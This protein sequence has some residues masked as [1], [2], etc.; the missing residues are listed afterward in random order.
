MSSKKITPILLAGGAGSRLWP[1]SRDDLPKQFQPLT[2]TFSTYQE[3]LRRVGDEA[4]YSPPIVI[5][6]EAFRFFSRRQ[7]EAAG[8]PATVVLEPARRDS[9]AAVAVAAVMAE[10]RA[11]ATLVLALAADH[12]V[13][14][15]DLF[16]KS[17]L[18]GAEAAAAGR[19]VVFGLKPTEPRTSYGYIRPGEAIDG[20]ADLALVDAFVEKPNAETALDYL[21]KGY[22]WNSG[23][24]LFR[25]DVMIA[26]FRKYAPE[27]LDAA[28]AS[29]D[30][31]STDLG[32]VRLDQ[33]SFEKAPKNSIDYA[34]IEKTKEMAV[35]TGH[36]RWSDVGSWDAIWEVLDRDEKD[37]VVYGDGMALNSSGCL[38]HSEGIY[39]T[40][41]GVDDL[42][43]IS[44]R[45]A[46][47]VVPKSKVQD[48]KK[49]VDE[50]K[51]A[52]VPQADGHRRSHRPWGTVDSVVEGAR[53]AV[54]HIT[55]DCGGV[56][57]LQKHM[58][59]S[60]HWVV[61]SGTATITIGEETRLVTENESVY[62]PLG[63]VHRIS[64]EGMVPL[65]LIEVRTGSYIHEDD[66]QRIEDIYART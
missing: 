1:V 41:V 57:S 38:I 56:L 29:V 16:T 47:M 5:T 9:A 19:I 53:Y 62:V 65:E 13:L 40:L 60:E 20:N 54:K 35:V 36:F 44:T 27:I 33:E 58:H 51:K 34:V 45:D 50:L 30:K 61:V 46:V 32:F 37:N 59:R 26:E 2:G 49:L 4:V 12:M 21:K 28:E 48:V 39:T 52:D 8:H 23:N 66:I 31:A 11:P 15:E 10:R 43:A 18:L 64:N 63:V 22:L 55:V 24:F 42:I 14:D 17:V 7:A 6:N 3:T 25:S